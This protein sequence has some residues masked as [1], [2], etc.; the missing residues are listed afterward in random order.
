M[1]G[2]MMLQGEGLLETG[3]G[4][5]GVTAYFVEH[6]AGAS[7]VT[8]PAQ[9]GTAVVDLVIATNQPI[10]A[11]SAKPAVGGAG[12]PP[13]DAAGVVSLD[14]TGWTEQAN[15]LFS[16]DNPGSTLASYYDFGVLDWSVAIPSLAALEQTPRPTGVGVETGRS[17]VQLAGP[18]AGEAF[19]G[20][21]SLASV[22]G[23]ISTPAGAVYTTSAPLGGYVRI[24]L[25]GGPIAVA[26]LTLHV[27]GTPGTYTL[28]LVDA[29][30]GD[31]YGQT[32]TM[33]AGGLFTI[34]V[35]GQ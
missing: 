30:Y 26:T 15:A 25:P 33:A 35:Q 17:L 27:S 29:T 13:A 18:Y 6:G 8:L 10:L 31:T 23:A 22:A 28:G 2:M 19:A 7:S 14:A 1:Q 20:V 4:S 24:P 21:E 16:L 9:G 32:Q 3:L 11:F 34:T 5:E 12:V